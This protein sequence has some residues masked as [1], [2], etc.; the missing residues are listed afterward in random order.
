MFRVRLLVAAMLAATML[1]T[2][3]VPAAAQGLEGWILHPFP[4]AGYWWCE[5]VE[6]G[7]RYE[8]YSYWCWA[9]NGE[10]WFKSD[11][12]WLEKTTVEFEQARARG[13]V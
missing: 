3:A 6:D 12:D 4:E 9:S 5:W 11:P 2:S 7:G 10:Y 1:V 13:Q 8:G